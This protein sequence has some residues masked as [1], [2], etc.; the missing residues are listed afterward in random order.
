MPLV[1]KVWRRFRGFTLIE[2][3]VVIAIIAILIS[4]LLPAVQKV[5]EAA[6]RAQSLNNLK[7]IGIAIHNC[8]DTY[9][10][11]PSVHGG[12]P[13]GNDPNWG[14]AYNP[15]HFGTINYFLLPFIEQQNVYVGHEINGGATNNPGNQGGHNGNS[16]WSSAIIPTYQAPGDPT[17][18]ASGAA[19]CCGQDGG[20]RGATSYAANWHVFR[21]GW[22]EDWQQGGHARIPATMPDGTS[23]TIGFFE[24]YAICGNPANNQ[25]W[26]NGQGS[27]Y[28]EHIWQ[29]DGQNAGPVAENWN[30]SNGG[31]LPWFV[32]GWWAPNPNPNQQ[33]FTDPNHPPPGYPQ[34]YITLPQIVPTPS[35]C[36]PHRLQAL[37]VGGINVLFMDGSAHSVS[38]AV[39]QATWAC[40]IMPDDGQAIGNDW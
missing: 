13:F 23:N 35:N 20:G 29:E 26:P 25:S 6:A 8:N 37:Q 40:L 5:R 24:R 17:L 34:A 32:P 7:Q 3:L 33:Y 30:P 14:A 21:G 38:P 9:K 2:L 11:C 4:L 36:D 1:G 31:S 19:W 15:S 18:P 10:H 16:W 27:L 28:V 12:F 39:S 22:G